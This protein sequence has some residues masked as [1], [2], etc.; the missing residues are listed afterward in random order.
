VKRK[1]DGAGG[2]KAKAKRGSDE[3]P[4]LPPFPSTP[5]FDRFVD[6]ARRILAVPKAAIDEQ[7]AAYKKGK[8]HRKPSA[9]V[10]LL[11]LLMVLTACTSLSPGAEKI[12]VTRNAKDVAG[13]KAVGEVSGL[14]ANQALPGAKKKMMNAA[15]ALGADTVFV[16]STVGSYDGVAYLC[17]SS[18]SR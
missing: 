18:G 5:T 6:F 10:R 15:L 11:L 2:G 9:K 8:P 14:T 17:G 7:E 4:P 12:K 16:T 13:C 1:K 3:L